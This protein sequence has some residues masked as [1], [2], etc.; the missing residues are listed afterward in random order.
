MKP[1]V[2]KAAIEEQAR[3]LMEGNPALTLAEARK[4]ARKMA[5]VSQKALANLAALFGSHPVL[6]Q[7]KM[8]G[9]K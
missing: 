2:N 3:L 8:P 5:R 6:S 9:D 1:K 4:E 7:L